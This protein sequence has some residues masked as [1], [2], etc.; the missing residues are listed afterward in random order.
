MKS[1]Y[2]EIDAILMNLVKNDRVNGTNLSDNLARSLY[3]G[4]RYNETLTS[5]R[6]AQ[7]R[8]EAQNIPWCPNN[9]TIRT[10]ILLTHGSHGYRATGY[11]DMY[12][13]W[14]S[15]PDYVA[16]LKSTICVKQVQSPI[17]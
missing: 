16:Y 14:Q 8:T 5:W 2:V 7:T 12:P 3:V 9:P 13:T 17:E 1:T 11:T 4:I 6:H 10:N 15:N